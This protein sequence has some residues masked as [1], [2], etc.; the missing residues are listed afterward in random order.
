MLRIYQ[1]ISYLNLDVV[2]GAICCSLFAGQVLHLTEDRTIMHWCLGLSIWLIY[3]ADRLL[4]VNQKGYQPNSRR[5]LFAKRH[6]KILTVL[7]IAVFLAD[8]YLA[9][10]VLQ[11]TLI[12]YGFLVLS[13]VAAYYILLKM[14]QAKR[15]IWFQK[16]PVIA[17]VYTMGV[18]GSNVWLSGSMTAHHF[19]Y[20][21]LPFY[22]LALMNL[23]LFSYFE[24]ER[25]EENAER[26]IAIMLGQKLTGRII[27]VCFALILTFSVTLLQVE[28]NRENLI[29]CVTRTAMGFILFS[30]YYR[31]EYFYEKERYRFVGDGVFMLPYLAISLL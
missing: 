7:C 18:W 12:V 16:E 11:H 15:A 22:C 25:D 2:A 28:P 27:M 21:L 29:I 10:F 20:L 1:L 19:F 9:L 5:H 23:L 17:A 4:D 14:L 8:T 3:T 30:L 26:S 13:V 31:N 6:I 24:T